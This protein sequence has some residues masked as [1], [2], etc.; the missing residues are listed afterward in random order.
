[1]NHPRVGSGDGVLAQ[2]GRITAVGTHRP[3]TAFV[4]S[5]GASLAA[6]Q[7]GMLQALYE[8]RIEPDLLVG[9]SAGALNAA[10]IASR[11]Q[12]AATAR[13]LARI[14]G[15][16]RRE[17]LFPV[18]MSALIGGFCG[19]R[20]HLVPDRGLRALTHRYL[21]FADLAEAPIPLHVVAFDLNEGREV[22]LSEGPA[23]D[24]IAASASIPGIYPA[25]AMGERRLVDGGVVNNAPISHAVALG[26]ERIYVLPAQ[27]RDRPSERPAKTALDAAI[28][29][30]G[31]L[32]TSRLESDIARYAGDAEIV[33]M[34]APNSAGVQPTSFEHSGALIAEALAAGRREL[35][36]QSGHPHLRL[37]SD[38]R[39]GLPAQRRRRPLA[40]RETVSARALYAQKKGS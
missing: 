12:T 16:L 15:D 24:S 23:V 19:R 17:D 5:G 10:F 38:S 30:L 13:M 4:L 28:Y 14:W 29:G 34:P 7:V 22:L 27:R 20:D 36:A 40:A 39:D 37:V 26:A 32:V 11:P 21:E 35:G 8:H 18:S 25:V 6:A 33:V 31:L 1:M 9:T 2:R 3:R